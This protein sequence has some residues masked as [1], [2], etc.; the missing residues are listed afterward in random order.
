MKLA[1]KKIFTV[2]NV[3]TIIFVCRWK[4]LILVLKQWRRYLKYWSMYRI[5]VVRYF[6]LKNRCK[7]YESI[8]VFTNIYFLS[9]LQLEKFQTASLSWMFMIY[10]TWGHFELILKTNTHTVHTLRIIVFHVFNFSYPQKH[11]KFIFGEVITFFL[12][13]L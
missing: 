6:L 7:F 11:K 5:L 9:R 12:S 13:L 8:I 1:Y 4:I 2:I 3:H 10:D